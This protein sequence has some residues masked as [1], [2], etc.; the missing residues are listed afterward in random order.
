MNQIPA[1]NPRSECSQFSPVEHGTASAATPADRRAVASSP[2]PVSPDSSPVSMAWS[3]T[4]HAH[5]T[6]PEN[7]SSLACGIDTVDV[8]LEVVWGAGWLKL[9][10]ELDQLKQQAA[11]TEGILAPDRRYLILPG[12][13]Q[14]SY[15]WHLQWPE[16][17]LFVAKGA[18]PHNQSP[19]LLASV[20]SETLWRHG[21]SAAVQ[22]VVDEVIKLGGHVRNIKP[23]RCDLSADF[24]IPDGLTLDFLLELRTPSQTKHSHN[25]SGENLETFYQ[26]GKKSPI[27]LRIYNKSLEIAAGGTKYWFYDIWKILPGAAVCAWNSR[28]AAKF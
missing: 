4:R 9:S 1:S 23:S 2:G 12:G 15:R 6:S 25:M 17:H 10:A 7:W 28:F 20:N 27:Q 18:E 16:F 26:G 3:V 8:G 19:N 24:L 21:L 22:L 5:F 11:G 14:P 13:R